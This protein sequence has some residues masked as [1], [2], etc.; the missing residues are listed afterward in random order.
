MVRGEVWLYESPTRKPR[1]VLLLSRDSA[2]GVLHTVVAVPATRTIRNIPTEVPLDESDGMRTA[3]VL[4]TDNVG[5]YNKAYLTRHLT[6]L[7]PERIAQVCHA[8][9]LA[10]DC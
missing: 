2:I 6:T 3:C 4:S 1:P 9:S 10:I 7:S 5:L 8:L